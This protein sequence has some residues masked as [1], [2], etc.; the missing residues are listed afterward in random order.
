MCVSFFT[1]LDPKEVMCPQHFYKPGMIH[2]VDMST[3]DM[4]VNKKQW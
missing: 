2:N 4:E 1:R 3:S